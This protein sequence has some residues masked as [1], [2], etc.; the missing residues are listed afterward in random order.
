MLL[1]TIQPYCVYELLR[2]KG[3]YR[4]NPELSSF[5]DTEEFVNAYEWISKKMKEKI[6]N[7][8]EGVKYPVWAYYCV[9]GEHKRPDMRKI[10][11]KVDKK[12]VLLEIEI[13]DSDVLLTD[14]TLWHCTLNDSINYKAN[15]IDD[16]SDEEWERL[17]EIEEDYYNSLSKENQRLYKEKSWEKVI[18]SKKHNLKYV[19]ATFWELKKS[20]IRKVW[21]LKK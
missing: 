2:L 6:G 4:C 16:I 18:C 17:T 3:I 11:F 20:Q 9:E 5:L 7:S 1:W 12:S 15:Y 21:V 13:P 19:Q 10:A 14:H 8:P